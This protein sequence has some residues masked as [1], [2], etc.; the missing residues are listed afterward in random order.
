MQRDRDGDDVASSEAW[1]LLPVLGIFWEP[2]L[3]Q[4]PFSSH[5]IWMSQRWSWEKGV[6]G[7]TETWQPCFLRFWI[8]QISKFPKGSNLWVPCSFWSWQR[9]PACHIW[10]CCR[11]LLIVASI[12]GYLTYHILACHIMF[13]MPCPIPSWIVAC[14]IITS[15]QI[16]NQGAWQHDIVF[17]FQLVFTVTLSS[18][19]TMSGHHVAQHIMSHYVCMLCC[20]ISLIQISIVSS[21]P[22]SWHYIHIKMPNEHMLISRCVAS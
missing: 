11:C 8:Q 2:R 14:H 12:P 17:N 9:T 7:Q 13:H 18:Q 22:F 5:G 21:C 15:H 10:S 1:Q 16:S 20:G 4:C 6:H 3:E 19:H